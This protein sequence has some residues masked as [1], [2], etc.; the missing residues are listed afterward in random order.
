MEYWGFSSWIC[1]DID[2]LLFGVEEFWFI[3]GRGRLLFCALGLRCR[4]GLFS[5]LVVCW[6]VFLKNCVFNL[7]RL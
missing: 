6:L 3:G 2:I 7:G 4:D 5:V 1:F